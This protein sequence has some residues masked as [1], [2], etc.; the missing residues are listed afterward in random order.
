MFSRLH[1]AVQQLSRIA[2]VAVD[3]MVL[4]TA[5]ALSLAI[6]NFV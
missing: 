5:F 3:L 6:L 1:Q 4:F 2:V